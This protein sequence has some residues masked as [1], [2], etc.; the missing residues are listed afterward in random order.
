MKDN[1]DQSSATW[2]TS[3]QIFRRLHLPSSHF[4]RC[5]VPTNRSSLRNARSL[6]ALCS[7]AHTKAKNRKFFNF[8]KYLY[9]LL[10]FVSKSF[11][12]W[13]TIED[14]FFFLMISSRFHCTTR[15]DYEV[16]LRLE[17]FVDYARGNE[18]KERTRDG[19]AWISGE[20]HRVAEF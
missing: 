5:P 12:P 9:L 10:I 1:I 20:I 16:L 8:M 19:V 6:G 3:R 11:H 13:S 2:C 18:G 15:G 4:P 14:V 17:R 7:G